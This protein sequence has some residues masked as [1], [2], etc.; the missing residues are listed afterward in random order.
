MVVP[1]GRR[2][3]RKIHACEPESFGRRIVRKHK[4]I[5]ND[6][7][8]IAL[9]ISFKFDNEEKIKITSSQH[10]YYLGISGKGFITPL[11]L[12]IIRRS[13]NNKRKILPLIKSVLRI[14]LRLLGELK[15]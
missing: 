15:K 4:D 5:K 9:G 8:F 1:F 13:I 14:S 2:S 6:D 10:K 12:D 3:G 11:G 7:Q